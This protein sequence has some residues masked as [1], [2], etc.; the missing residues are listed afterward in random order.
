MVTAD[1]FAAINLVG[2]LV[3]VV[4]R[5]DLVLAAFGANADAAVSIDIERKRTFI[6]ILCYVLFCSVWRLCGTACNV[7]LCCA[8]LSRNWLL[9]FTSVR[10]DDG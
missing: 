6:L 9:M 7:M 8:V 5:V 3:L 1:F 2:V 10:F 4:N